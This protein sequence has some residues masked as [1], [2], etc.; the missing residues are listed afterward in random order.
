VP[1]HAPVDDRA[2]RG[3]CRD[4]QEEP[5]DGNPDSGARSASKLRRI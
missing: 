1:P 2:T 3:R 5:S 4:P